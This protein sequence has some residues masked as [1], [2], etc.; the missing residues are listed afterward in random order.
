M[1]DPDLQIKGG[2]GHPVPEI[3]GGSGLKKMF[4]RPFGP[5]LGPKIRESGPL[6]PS[7]ESATAICFN[8]T[9]HDKWCL[10]KRLVL[11]K[12]KMT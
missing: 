9:V 1:A 2:G 8:E 12:L 10:A 7:P 3:R 6:G 5:Q 4:F 11:G